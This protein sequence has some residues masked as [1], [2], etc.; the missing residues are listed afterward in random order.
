MNNKIAVIF[1]FGAEQVKKISFFG[2]KENQVRFFIDT[3]I[4]ANDVEWAR[5][6]LI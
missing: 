4:V 3:R 2:F 6:E 1:F 5:Y